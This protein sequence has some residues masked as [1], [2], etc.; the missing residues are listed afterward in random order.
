MYILLSDDKHQMVRENSKKRTGCPR[1][2]ASADVIVTLMFLGY[3]I[4]KTQT[5]L[6]RMTRL[7]RMAG[8]FEKFIM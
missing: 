8:N 1:K 3:G 6:C 7:F 4:I 2:L 5:G